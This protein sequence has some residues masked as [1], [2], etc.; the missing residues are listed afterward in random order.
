MLLQ[1]LEPEGCY[2]EQT[3]TCSIRENDLIK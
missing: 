3:L 2:N 1:Y